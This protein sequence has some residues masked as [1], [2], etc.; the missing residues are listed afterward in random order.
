MISHI[1]KKIINIRKSKYKIT[2]HLK[3]QIEKK[4]DFQEKLIKEERT[5]KILAIFWDA[6]HVPTN[7]QQITW[8]D[9]NIRLLLCDT[10]KISWNNS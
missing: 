7:I 1:F 6:R 2:I 4:S 5:E 10:I 3:T 8:R 9:V